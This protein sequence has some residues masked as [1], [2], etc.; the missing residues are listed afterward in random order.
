MNRRFPVL[1]LACQKF[2]RNVSCFQLF[3]YEVEHAHELRKNKDLMLGDLLSI[4]SINISILAEPSPCNFS[5]FNN[6]GELQICRNRVSPLNTCMLFF[7]ISSLVMSVRKSRN[8][9]SQV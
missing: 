1:C 8:S 6:C 9:F 2:K 3:F 4:W 7:E 5:S